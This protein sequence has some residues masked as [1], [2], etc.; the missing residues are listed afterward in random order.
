[1]YPMISCL[2][3]LQKANQLV[4]DYKAELKSEGIAFD[5]ALEIGAMIEIPSA[6]LGSE[7]LAK[8]CK[9]FSVGTN[10][11]IQ[12]SMAV[13]RLNE[14]IAHLYE[15]TN[16]AILRLIKITVDAAHKHGIW[17]GVCG[18]MASDPVLTPLLLGLGV[19]ELSVAPANVPQIKFLIRRLKMAEARDLA[20]FA[21]QCEFGSEVLAR[22]ESYARSIAPSLFEDSASP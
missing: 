6:A 20:E 21:L 15:P 12:Y 10:D 9:F 1:M 22:A 11:L 14:K 18:E 16:P 19:D 13:D 5:S 3:E 17:T 8:R 2:D 7:A 4:E